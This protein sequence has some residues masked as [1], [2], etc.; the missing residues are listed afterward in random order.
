MKNNSLGKLLLPLTLL[1]LTLIGA[2]AQGLTETQVDNLS[3]EIFADPIGSIQPRS[4]PIMGQP[5]QAVAVDLVADNI[6]VTQGVQDLNNS[7]RLVEGK[8]TFVRFYASSNSTSQRT[9]ATLTVSRGSQSITLMEMPPLAECYQPGSGCFTLDYYTVDPSP[10]RFNIKDDFLWRLP[11]YFPDGSRVA[12]GTV[13]LTAKVNP[14]TSWRDRSPVE[15]TYSNNTTTVT[16]DFEPAQ[17][18]FV[19]IYKMG[20]S[21]NG[22]TVHYPSNTDVEKLVEWLEAAYPVTSVGYEVRSHNLGNFSAMGDGEGELNCN[23]VNEFLHERATRLSPLPG[24]LVIGY[25]PIP[26]GARFY[27]LVDAVDDGAGNLTHFMRGCADIPGTEFDDSV[28]V[29]WPPDREPVYVG[30]GPTGATWASHTWD[31]D[32]SW[33]DWYGGHEL[34][35]TYR[36]FH[37]V[38]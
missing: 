27:G 14:D 38:G 13:T 3:A 5:D 2:Q 17:S 22:G 11:K 32:G 4:S 24:S 30:S 21:V 34:G 16:V 8:P 28:P 19:V 15:T 20:Y 26:E 9:T 23:R 18:I 33:G 35:H 36:R 7:V 10:S 29:L 1:F 6:E 12:Q 37:L 31:K 25:K